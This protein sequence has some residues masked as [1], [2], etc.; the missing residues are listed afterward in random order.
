MNAPISRFPAS[1]ACDARAPQRGLG[2]CSSAD[3]F[4]SRTGRRLAA[5]RPLRAR[6]RPPPAAATLRC[7]S[8]AAASAARRRSS[9]CAASAAFSAFTAAAFF[10][11]PAIAGLP[12]DRQIIKRHHRRH[13][14]AMSEPQGI[15]FH[16]LHLHVAVELA[17][18]GH[19]IRRQGPRWRASIASPRAGMF[20]DAFLASSSLR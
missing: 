5:H 2:A 10:R 14:V 6:A 7:S 3:F 4:R 11:G 9:A 20:S 15:A 8:S 13:T 1:A 16:V 17:S 19:D 12:R 18:T